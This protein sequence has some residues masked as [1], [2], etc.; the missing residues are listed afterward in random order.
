M[1]CLFYVGVGIQTST[2]RDLLCKTIY[3]RCNQ[4]RKA[5]FEANILTFRILLLVDSFQEWNNFPGKK[6]LVVRNCSTLQLFNRFHHIF[7]LYLGSSSETSPSHSMARERESLADVLRCGV[8][9]ENYDE[10]GEHIP[11]LLPCSH[12][13]CESCIKDIMTKTT[14]KCPECRK[15]HRCTNREKSFPQN[16]YLLIHICGNKNDTKTSN[17]SECSTDNVLKEKCQEHG[18][19]LILYCF[20]AMCKKSI[21]ISCLVDHNKHDVKS[22]DTKEKEFLKEELK[23]NK[24][25]LE[26]RLNFLLEAG[27]NAA[28]M[29]DKCLNYLKK[30]KDEFVRCFDK[31]IGKSES[32]G[33][34]TKRQTDEEVSAITA[35][36]EVLNSIQENL[37]S[38]DAANPKTI[39]N[40]RETVGVIIENNKKNL[41]CARSFKF[42]VF[43]TDGLSA[44]MIAKRIT[45]EEHIQ[46]LSDCED[47]ESEETKKLTVQIRPSQPG[48]SGTFSAVL[49]IKSHEILYF[50]FN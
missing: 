15:K 27:K 22:I 47:A 40:Y 30:T 37:E 3:N 28:D 31:Q 14:L 41:S 9:W 33:N 50:G 32:K 34:Q 44:E 26:A 35:S 19:E 18:H 42:P 11:R 45:S 2:N 20:E 29:T 6:I 10:N 49:N 23:L 13:V 36:I 1:R 24:T 16:K 17:D 46:E 48:C 8:C 12:T 25:K 21:C 38:S 5:P 39:E 43:N 4:V 7:P